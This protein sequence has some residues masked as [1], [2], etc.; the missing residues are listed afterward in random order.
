MRSV[1]VGYA[2]N[3]RRVEHR[4]LVSFSIEGCTGGRQGGEVVLDSLCHSVEGCMGGTTVW[5]GSVR[6]VRQPVSQHRGVYGG[7]DSVGR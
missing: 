5:G 3:P 2:S 7:D 1:F 4:L 6:C